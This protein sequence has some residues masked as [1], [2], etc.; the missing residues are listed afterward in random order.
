M[1][2]FGLKFESNDKESKFIVGDHI[3]ISKYE[4]V[5]GKLKSEIYTQ[6]WSKKVFELKKV[7]NT[8]SWH[9]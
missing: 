7:E 2:Y 5:S 6:N 4:N 1:K 8:V 3:R 9:I